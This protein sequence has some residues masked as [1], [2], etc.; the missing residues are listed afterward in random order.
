MLFSG[1]SEM[2]DEKWNG[3]FDLSTCTFSPYNDLNS[4]ASVIIHNCVCDL[5]PELFLMET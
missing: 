1:N 4:A 3:H 5:V 2:I